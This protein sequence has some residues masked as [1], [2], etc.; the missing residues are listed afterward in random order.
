[1]KEIM[2]TVSD[3]ASSTQVLLDA[4]LDHTHALPKIEL[5]LEKTIDIKDSVRTPPTIRPQPNLVI[6]LP[7]RVVTVPVPG[8]FSKR[9]Y[10]PGGKASIPQPPKI[11]NKGR[12]RTRIRKQE[13]NFEAIIGGTE[14]PRFTAPVQTDKE[15]SAPIDPLPGAPTVNREKTELGMKTATINTDLEKIIDKFTTQR[16]R[17]NELTLKVNHFLSKN[18]FVN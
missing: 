9:V 1:M 13:I 5:N 8:G 6:N 10:V 4:F 16:E 12:T 3:F 11:V 17:L 7:G 15:S 2:N 14:N 18:Q